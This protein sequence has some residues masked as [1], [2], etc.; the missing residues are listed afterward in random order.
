[1]ALKHQPKPLVEEHYHIDMLIENQTKR[2]ED[3]QRFKDL[4]RE[5]AENEK[6]IVD[7]KA[8]ALLD[9]FCDHCRQDFRSNAVLHIELDWNKPNEQIAFY[10]G[11]H[12]KCG[13]WSVR[14]WTDKAQDGFF[15]KS[16]SVA[17]DRGKHFEDLLQPYQIGF[18]TLYGKPK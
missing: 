9:F 5:R 16:R 8:V 17:I 13:R 18:N 10:R 6:M 15:M 7:A 2:S 12:R 14:H 11:K 4:D 3:R 1:M